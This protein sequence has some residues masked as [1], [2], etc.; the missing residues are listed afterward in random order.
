[1]SQPVI[2]LPPLPDWA[3]ALMSDGRYTLLGKPSNQA[4]NWMHANP[5]G[6]RID[7]R[8]YVDRE[9]RVLTS[10]TH[11]GREAEGRPGVA[12]GGAIATVLDDVAGT[13]GWLTG[14][15]VVSLNLD[16]DFRAYVPTHVWVRTEGEVTK[17]DGRKVYVTCRITTPGGVVD[18][19]AAQSDDRGDKLH[20]EARGLFL[21]VET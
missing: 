3:V 21:H 14:M 17:V 15:P 12:H 7:S 10:V 16:I 13:T 11:F 1:M 4:Q 19:A 20:A 6:E 5:S 8:Y 2:E 18:G 9:R